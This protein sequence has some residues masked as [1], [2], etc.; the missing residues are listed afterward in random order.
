MY[1]GL[2]QQTAGG[3]GR[4]ITKQVFH[5]LVG[6]EEDTGRGYSD[7]RN[8]ADTLVEVSPERVICNGRGAP[9]RLLERWRL[10]ACF[11]CVEWEDEEIDADSGDDACLLAVNA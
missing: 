5:A 4:S 1:G 10:E 6:G 2:R 3:R 9:V 8:C 7:E 11:E